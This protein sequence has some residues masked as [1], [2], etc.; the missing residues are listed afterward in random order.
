M[1]FFIYPMING[2]YFS[3]T[4][5]NGVAKVKHF[6][7]LKNYIAIFNDAETIRAIKNTL[8]YTVAV[9]SFS[10]IIGLILALALERRSKINNIYRTIFFIPAVLS[11]VVASF[12]W[13]YMYSPES[14]VINSVLKVLG[15]NSLAQDW[16]GNPKLALMSVMLVPIWQWGGNVMVVFLAGLMNIPDEYYE[17]STID[18]VSYL[19]RIRYITLPLLKPSMVFNVVISTIGS[20]K[21]FDFIFILTNGGPG[22]FTEVLTLRVYNF[23]LYTSRFGYGSAVATVLTLLV[24]IFSLTELKILTRNSERYG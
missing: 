15:L 14:G 7:G 12:I 9:T 6:V 1:F 22:F 19:Q 23:T 4:D 3:T 5:W 24:I 16:L 2:L 18:G 13:K 21:T 17:A 10:I 20:L 11:P 8:I